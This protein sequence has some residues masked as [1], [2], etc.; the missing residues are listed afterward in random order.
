MCPSSKYQGCVCVS[1]SACVKHPPPYWL[2]YVILTQSRL[3]WEEAASVEEWPCQPGLYVLCLWG[4]FLIDDWCGKAQSSWVVPPL[5]KWSW[6]VLEKAN[7]HWSSLASSS[8]PASRFL[9]WLPSE[10]VCD[11]RV[12][13]PFPL[14]GVLGI[15]FHHSNRNPN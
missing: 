13:R 3:I 15:V 1:M 14:Q 7:K 4:V 10:M 12:T 6:V 5:G 11:L 8:V 2:V 9:L